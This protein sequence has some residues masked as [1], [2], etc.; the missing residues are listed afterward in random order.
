MV[1]GVWLAAV[2]SVSAEQWAVVADREVVGRQDVSDVAA[3]C[4]WWWVHRADRIPGTVPV[5][6]IRHR[7]RPAS[8]GRAA[9]A[10]AWGRR[11]GRGLLVATLLRL[12]AG[13]P[14]SAR[15]LLPELGAIRD[16]ISSL[17]PR[18]PTVP[19]GRPAGGTIPL[20]CSLVV[21]DCPEPGA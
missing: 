13:T 12:P 10:R 21:P 2:F 1:S 6:S 5:Q 8:E 20:P 16:R 11:R 18:L 3:L 17:L 15:L 14:A 7:R 9:H 4:E 19:R